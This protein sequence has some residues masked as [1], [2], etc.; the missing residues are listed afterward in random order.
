M[1]DMLKV[2]YK[3]ILKWNFKVEK[4]VQKEEAYDVTLCKWLS[5]EVYGDNRFVDETLRLKPHE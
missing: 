3:Y 2:I 4:V 1:N 5:P